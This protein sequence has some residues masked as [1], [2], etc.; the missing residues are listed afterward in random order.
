MV[1]EASVVAWVCLCDDDARIFSLAREA[2]QPNKQGWEIYNTDTEP[3]PAVTGDWCAGCFG[4]VF[5]VCRSKRVLSSLD[6]RQS[7]RRQ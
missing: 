7:V 6:G 5:V 3:E 4:V 2:Q 1:F